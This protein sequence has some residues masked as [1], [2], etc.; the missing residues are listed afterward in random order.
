L[1]QNDG[2]TEE[3]EKIWAKKKDQFEKKAQRK[4]EKEV[5][6]YECKWKNRK[7]GK[8]R[9]NSN[10]SSSDDSCDKTTEKS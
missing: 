9:K 4:R 1:E 7:C 5:R 3:V 10:S 8:N 6:K 2:N